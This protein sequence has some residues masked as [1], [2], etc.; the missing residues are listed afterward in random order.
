MLKAIEALV[1]VKLQF[2]TQ[3]HQPKLVAQ[4]NQPGFDGQ[5]QRR[6]G[7]R[8]I[9]NGGLLEKCSLGLALTLEPR[10]A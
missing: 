6:C 8:G 4:G 3:M 1:L 10:A 7:H 5:S 2:N 9:K